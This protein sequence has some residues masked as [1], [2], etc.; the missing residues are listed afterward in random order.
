MAVC[1][2]VVGFSAHFIRSGDFYT[3]LRFYTFDLWP[4]G[5]ILSLSY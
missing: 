4:L 1:C 3:D 5:V 2:L